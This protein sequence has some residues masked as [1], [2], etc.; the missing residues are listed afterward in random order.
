MNALRAYRL[1]DRARQAELQLN[2]ADE[3]LVSTC[4]WNVAA[5]A[6]S[7]EGTADILRILTQPSRSSDARALGHVGLAYLELAHGRWKRS[8]GSRRSIPTWPDTVR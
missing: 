1:G 7:F 4:A 5:F 6:A 3:R 2:G 8:N